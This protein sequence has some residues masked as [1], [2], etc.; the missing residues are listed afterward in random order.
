[1][2][3][4]SVDDIAIGDTIRFKTLSA[5]DN[6]VWTGDVAS[7]CNYDTAK[8][9]YDIDAYYAEI[10]RTVTSLTSKESLTYLVVKVTQS[11][12]ST[13]YIAVAKDWIDASTL[14]KVSGNSHTDI[15]I[16]N[17]DS[18]KAND[19]LSYIKTAYPGYNAEILS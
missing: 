8:I 12:N 16:Y 7:I 15:R 13:A 2:S 19:I 6:V 17:I 18:S 1:M 10:K 14:E 4:E 11:D 9:F 5:H 3:V